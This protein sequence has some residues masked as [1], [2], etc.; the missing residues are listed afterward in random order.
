M[1]ASLKACATE[2][3]APEGSR[4]GLKVAVEV[5]TLPVKTYV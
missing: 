5:I 1:P 4:V 2:G 3:E